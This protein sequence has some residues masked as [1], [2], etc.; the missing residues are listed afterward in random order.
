MDMY[1][2]IPDV[3][4]VAQSAAANISIVS[5]ALLLRNI[6]ATPLPHT[7][8]VPLEQ[9]VIFYITALS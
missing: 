8:A 5:A 1:P 7:T 4:Y 2:A 3:N 6:S 9:E